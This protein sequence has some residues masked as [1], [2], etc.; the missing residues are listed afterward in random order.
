MTQPQP[1]PMQAIQPGIMGFDKDINI[2]RQTA[3]KVVAMSFQVLPEDQRTPIG[4]IAACEVW[5]AY[6]LHGPLRFG[7]TA[8]GDQPA[9]VG[10]TMNMNGA[11]DPDFQSGDPH[12]IQLDGTMPCPECGHTDAHAEGCP[13]ALPA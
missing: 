6:F 12:F 10:V 5:M 8:F 4:M 7:V 1:E 13:A 2:M 9:A 11:P 3:A